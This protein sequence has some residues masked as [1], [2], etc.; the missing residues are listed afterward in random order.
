MVLISNDLDTLPANFLVSRLKRAKLV[1]DSHE[2]FTE[3]PELEGRKFVKQFWTL[4]E[5]F[6]VP[7]VDVAYTVNESLAKMYSAKYGIEFGVIRNIPDNLVKEK[8]Y[9][10]PEEF[11]NNG[12][13]I[14]QG[15]INKDRGL[16]D[17]MELIGEEQQLRMVIAGDGDIMESLKTRAGEIGIRDRVLFTGSLKPARLKSLTKKA[18]LGISLEKKTNLN[19]YY[20]LPNKLFDYI[21]AGIPVLCSG[22]PEMRK[23][24]EHYEVGMIVDPGKREEIKQVLKMMF[25]DVEKQQKWR[26]NAKLAA[27]ELT[28]KTKQK[29]IADIFKK[30]GLNLEQVSD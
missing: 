3:V 5:R 20:A 21:H 14:Y 15:A 22:F 28:W 9:S 25:F 29:K 1:Y 24:V 11:E 18:R 8:K 4:L 12:F 10:L 16:E 27:E 13:I 23:I 17:V 2:Y 19:Y 7:K 6:L 30:A 26:E